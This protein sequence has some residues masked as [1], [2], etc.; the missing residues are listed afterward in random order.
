MWTSLFTENRHTTTS[1]QNA[2]CSQ[3]GATFEVAPFQAYTSTMNERIYG[4]AF[5]DIYPLYLAK[6]ERKGRSESELRTILTWLTGYDEDGLRRVME[7][8][9]TMASFFDQAPELHENR[10]LITGSIC[11]YR[12]ED[13]ADP[14]MQNIRYLDKLVDELA[15]GK[16]LEKILR[17]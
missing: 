11:G 15:R 1:R 10:K 9:V 4:M 13:I 14:L 16:A 7:H 3:D 12:V 17:S 5:S 2:R 6:I 8:N